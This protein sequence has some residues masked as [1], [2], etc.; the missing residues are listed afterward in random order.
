MVDAL[1]QH[2]LDRTIDYYPVG[3]LPTGTGKTIVAA[4]IIRNFSDLNLPSLIVAPSVILLKQHQTT[5]A[6]FVHAD[7][8]RLLQPHREMPG[9]AVRSANDT[10]DSVT[11][12]T[13]ATVCRHFDKLTTTLVDRKLAIVWDEVHFGINGATGRVIHSLWSSKKA[14]LM[15]LTA[16]PSWHRLN[17]VVYRKDASE[18]IETGVMASPVVRAIRTQSVLNARLSHGDIAKESLVKLARDERR[19]KLIVA[20]IQAGLHKGRFKRVLL[21][22]IDIQHAR[23]LNDALGKAGISSSV[24]DSKRTKESNDAAIAGF[25]QGKL[26]VLINVTKLAIG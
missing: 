10:K 18:L 12:A 20:E 14:L 3:V 15:G 4:S 11:F 16:T 17:K 6:D 5:L 7:K 21:F 23:T 2:A 1:L 8:F 26:N 24:V 22:A 13:C 19:N 9:I 25:R